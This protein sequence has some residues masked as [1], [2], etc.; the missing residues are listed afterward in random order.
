MQNKSTDELTNKEKK[1]LEQ[2][3]ITTTGYDNNANGSKN[4][5]KSEIE[6]KWLLKPEQVDILYRSHPRMDNDITQFYTLISDDEEIRFRKS[7]D[8]NYFKYKAVYYKT[9][10]KTIDNSTLKREEIEIDI[11]YKEYYK[12]YSIIRLKGLKPIRK[13]RQTYLINKK[14]YEV[15][16]YK[17]KEYKN[18]ITLE[19]EFDSEEEAKNFVPMFNNLEEITD[20]KEYKNK[21]I[22]K[23]I[24]KISKL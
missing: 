21:S 13:L 7:V 6:R 14:R 23:Q 20:K 8:V 18:L 3:N 16:I 22:F 12:E 17:N 24:N 15:D 9:I 4:N 19:I 2:L 11:P 5:S 10:K 1:T